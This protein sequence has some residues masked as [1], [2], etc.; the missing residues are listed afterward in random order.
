MRYFRDPAPWKS[1]PL[2]AVMLLQTQRQILNRMENIM[3]T[4]DELL[5][6]VTEEGTKIDSLMTFIDGLKQQIDD[7]N[8]GLSADEQAKVDA[9]FAGVAAN[10]EKVVAALE[11]ATPEPPVEP[12]AEEPS[13]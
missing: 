2:W 6:S 13:R 11:P 9:I 4:L 3:A 1:A 12:P 8:L 5:A 7:L 10:K